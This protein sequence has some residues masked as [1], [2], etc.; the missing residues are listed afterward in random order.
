MV[1]QLRVRGKFELR[2]RYIPK[3]KGITDIIEY[4]S[5]PDKQSLMILSKRNCVPEM[6][7]IN[8]ESYRTKINNI[9]ICESKDNIHKITGKTKPWRIKHKNLR[10]NADFPGA[11]LKGKG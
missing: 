3:N 10:R 5:D 4:D 6:H 2:N 7:L 9:R 1:I 8:K 11:F